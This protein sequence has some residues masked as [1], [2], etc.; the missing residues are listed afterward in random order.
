MPSL[1]LLSSVLYILLSAG[2]YVCFSDCVCVPP[3]QTTIRAWWR[4][5][6]WGTGSPA[7]STLRRHGRSAQKDDDGSHGKLS[8]LTAPRCVLRTLFLL[9]QTLLILCFFT[10]RALWA[11]NQTSIAGNWSKKEEII[12]INLTPKSGYP[13]GNHLWLGSWQLTPYVPL[14]LI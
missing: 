9:I 4:Q 10:S 7:P 12:I 8:A 2:S 5:E 11:T 14:W 6:C 1:A 13:M 3:L